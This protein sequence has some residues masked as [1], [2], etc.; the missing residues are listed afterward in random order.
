MA[1]DVRQLKPSKSLSV[2]VY[3]M[4]SGAHHGETAARNSS[5]RLVYVRS[6]RDVMVLMATF[7]GFRPFGL[8]RLNRQI[9]ISA[10]AE[11]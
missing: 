1:W 6:L 7:E 10:C 11:P 2:V 5:A 8:I 4:A 9:G 3:S